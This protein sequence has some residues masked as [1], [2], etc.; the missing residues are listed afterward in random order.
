MK[1]LTGITVVLA[2][3]GAL[4]GIFGMSE[5]GL[6]FSLQE[7]GGFWLVSAVIIALSAGRTDRPAPHRLGLGGASAGQA[8]PR[9]G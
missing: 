2:G 5:A 6:A 7:G 3:I 9:R 4:A 1:R 8:D